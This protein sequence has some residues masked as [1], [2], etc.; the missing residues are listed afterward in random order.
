M[1]VRELL[2]I[3]PSHTLTQNV[4]YALP[5]RSVHVYV[6]NNLTSIEQSNDGTT[7]TAVTLDDDES[8]DAAALFIRSTGVAT[9]IIC[10]AR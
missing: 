6:Q 8:F 2:T 3:G 10:K 4:T 7:W 5:A 9:I 1:A